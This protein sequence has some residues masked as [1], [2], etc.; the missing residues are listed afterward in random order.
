MRPTP[1]ENWKRERKPRHLWYKV[2]QNATSRTRSLVPR[3]AIPRRLVRPRVAHLF[4]GDRKPSDQ[5]GELL[6]VLGIMRF[7]CARQSSQTFVITHYRYGARYDRW[8]RLREYSL[9]IRHLI[10]SREIRR[11]GRSPRNLSIWRSVRGTDRSRNWP[12]NRRAGRPI[13]SQMTGKWLRHRY[14]PP[15]AGAIANP[16]ISS[17]ARLGGFVIRMPVADLVRTVPR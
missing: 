17:F 8:R 1:Q 10:T 12:A 2:S 16:V 11:R 14:F 3:F 7:D 13:S 5:T 9:H 4:D 15:P 6:Q